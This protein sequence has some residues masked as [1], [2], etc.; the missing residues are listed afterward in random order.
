MSSNHTLSTVSP[1]ETTGF[2]EKLASLLH[3]G[4]V[5]TLEGDLGAGKT[6]FTKGLAKG[7]GVKRTVNSPTFTIVKEYEGRLPLYHLDVYRLEDS[8]EDIGFDE[9]FHGDGVSVVEWAHFIEPYLPKRRLDIRISYIGETERKI[10]LS[11]MGEDFDRVCE[12]LMK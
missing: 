2:A 9:Y 10:E 5:L 7:L 8:D 6:T 11:P 4:D 12:E 1:E 3:A